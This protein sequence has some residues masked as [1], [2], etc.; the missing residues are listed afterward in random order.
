LNT[1]TPAVRFAGISVQDS[2]SNVGVTGSIFW[3][4]LCNKWVYSN[5]SGIGYSG[6]MLLSGPR[7]TTL[8]SESPLT[9]NYIAK[10]GGGDHLYDSCIQEV[11]GSVTIGGTLC[12][13]GVVCGASGIF[14]STS[15]SNLYLDGTNASGWG[16]NI[17][18]KSQG[19]DFGYV[20]SI[21][22]LVG[23]TTKDMTIWSTTGNGFR[24]YT[25]GNN[26][27]LCIDSNGISTFA[28]QVCTIALITV[29]LRYTGTGYITYDTS[30]SGTSCLIFRQNGTEKMRISECGYLAVTGNEAL[31]C[32]PYLQGMSFGWNR[33][34]GQGESMINWTNAG[35]GSACDLVF[36]F[37]DSSTLYERLRIASTGAATFNSSI[38]AASLS[39][40]STTNS[41]NPSV[42]SIISAGGLGLGGDIFMHPYN[43]NQ[44]NYGYIKT[45]ATTVNTTTLTLGTTY[46]YATNVDA[47][48]FFNGSATFNSSVTLTNSVFPVLT[49]QGT[50]SSPHIGSTWS[51]SANQDGN[52]RT[53]I[54]TACQGRAMYF[55]NSGDINI[56][57]NTLSVGST[58]SA[59]QFFTATNSGTIQNNTATTI[60]T[61]SGGGGVWLV[62]YT[63]D[64][65]TPQAGYAIVGNARGSTLY[66][67]GSGVGSQTSLS[68]SGLNLQLTQTAGVALSYKYSAIKLNS[69]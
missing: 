49:V 28:C 10:S 29:D 67:Y 22:S 53:I 26:P 34:N 61:S 68:V 57:N 62:T 20:G 5:P 64:G 42:G 47:V 12:T 60:F 39:I 33:T 31:S 25:N 38:S 7:T 55:E 1:D 8:G 59:T 50:A 2:G 43:A 13:S 18:F 32:V 30:A 11:S 19:T 51:V 35:G 15:Y 21:G 44:S 3:D 58:V 48:S 6:G 40:G 41:T 36:N 45:A 46:G 27:R 52:G 23:S 65:N 63:I 69:I 16:N 14:S 24:V 66:I 9:C 37:R 54:G 17:A 4:G 56:P